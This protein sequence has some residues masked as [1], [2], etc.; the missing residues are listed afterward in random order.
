MTQLLSTTKRDSENTSGGKIISKTLARQKQNPP[1]L[2]FE[3]LLLELTPDY[4]FRPSEFGT[5]SRHLKKTRIDSDQ[6]PPSNQ[7]FF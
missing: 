1:R 7:Y 3:R 4:G 6:Y 2:F 5:F